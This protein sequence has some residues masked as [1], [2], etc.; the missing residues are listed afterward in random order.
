MAVPAAGRPLQPF[1]A[2]PAWEPFRLEAAA[3]WDGARL[4]LLFRLQGPL[5]QLRLPAPT[6]NPER[7][8]G[9]WQSSCFEAFLGVVGQAPYWE[10]NLCPSG[11][12]NLYAL[13]AYRQGLRQEP[14]VLTL[15]YAQRRLPQPGGEQLL[16]LELDLELPALAEALAA[17]PQAARLEGSTTAVL[18][19]QQHGCS[20]W[21]WRHGGPEADFHRRESFMPL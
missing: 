15:P 11:H 8:D 5:Q 9:L 14:S 10:I 3:G 20:Y 16:E 7:R 12:W 17:D 21:A 18:D 6:P 2:S 1:A 4:Q 13:S 19:H